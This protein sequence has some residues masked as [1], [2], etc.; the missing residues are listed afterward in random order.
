MK[1]CVVVD[2][3]H[4]LIKGNTFVLFVFFVFSKSVLR[5]KPARF[6][7]ILYLLM[8]RKLRLVSHSRFKKRFLEVVHRWLLPIEIEEFCKRILIKRSDV[9]WTLVQSFREAGHPV[10]LA[11][12]APDVYV[13]VIVRMLDFDMYTATRSNWD[14]ASWYESIR[15]RKLQDVLSVLKAKG[16]ELGVVITDHYDDL[17]LLSAASRKIIVSP[18]QKTIGRLR[19]AKLDFEI[20]EG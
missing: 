5:F 17:P 8:L 12:A 16:L 10:C 9:V 20:I 11:T 19:K 18:G 7:L 13:R 6:G 15:E 14:E 3:D 2:L 1:R 4:T